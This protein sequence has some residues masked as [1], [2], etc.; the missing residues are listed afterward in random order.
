[1]K[2]A[3]L[4]DLD[5]VIINS[6]PMWSVQEPP[7]LRSYLG[8]TIGNAIG[9]SFG[10]SISQVYEKAV[11]QGFTGSL[12]DLHGAYHD[13]ATHIYTRAPLTSGIDDLIG[14]LASQDRRLGVVSSSPLPTI[15][16]V[17]S[18]LL[19]GSAI[20]IRISVDNH[21]VLKPKPAP[22]GYV[23]AMEK[24]QSTP[25]MTIIVEDSPTGIKAAMQTGAS[26]ICFTE[27]L[28][29]PPTQGVMHYA[30]NVM[31]LRR[32]ITYLDNSALK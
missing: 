23:H 11:V 15:Q 2:R 24:L 1:M 8:E 9:S 7:F 32:I 14:T 26:V 19:N 20:P 16:Y 12:E 3:V 10:L 27:H 30:S 13:L 5:G 22:D 28:E 21:P 6:E 25:E 29:T 4:F 31:E 18:R 17:L